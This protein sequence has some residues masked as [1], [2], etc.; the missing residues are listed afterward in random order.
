MSEIEKRFEYIK[1]LDPNS[2]RIVIEYKLF[3]D[4]K[5]AFNSP[6]K[7]ELLLRKYK[8]VFEIGEY[9]P[10]EAYE[11]LVGFAKIKAHMA[12]DLARA[13]KFETLVKVD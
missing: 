7:S 8:R 2:V 12:D 5:E 6:D 1:S 13:F 3:V 9:D 11:E 10:Q 4:F